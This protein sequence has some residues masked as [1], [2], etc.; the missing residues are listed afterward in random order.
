[1]FAAEIVIDALAPEER[2]VH[3][4]VTFG[5]VQLCRSSVR[6]L[7]AVR[8][9]Q[10][11]IGHLAVR[12][13]HGGICV[14]DVHL[15]GGRHLC[16]LGKDTVTLAQYGRDVTAR[17]I[18][19]AVFVSGF[20]VEVADIGIVGHVVIELY[21]RI[22]RLSYVQF[23]KTFCVLVECFVVQVL[24]QAVCANELAA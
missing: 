21:H 1:M 17:N 2:F 9:I 5:S 11:I 7:V 6:I 22:F 12:I 16:N 15:T 19:V 13:I 3:H 23:I 8:V 4:P 14:C 24:C 18:S 20:V 10:G